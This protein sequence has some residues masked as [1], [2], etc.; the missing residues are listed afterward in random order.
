MLMHR[1]EGLGR[2][3][4]LMLESDNDGTPR[5]SA[6][7]C[8]AL[9]LWH[10]RHPEMAVVPDVDVHNTDRPAIARRPCHRAFIMARKQN[11]APFGRNPVDGYVVEILE[12]F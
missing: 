6:E 8:D 1:G 12:I 5:P 3:G 9:A 7:R 10:A 11:I 2:D 4:L